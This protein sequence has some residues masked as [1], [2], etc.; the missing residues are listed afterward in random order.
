MFEDKRKIYF[1]NELMFGGSLFDR[2]SKL[3][4]FNEQS[5]AK[6]IRQLLSAITYLHSQGYVH[7]DI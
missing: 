7:G 2:I 1:V 3:K 5:V 4:S 6:I